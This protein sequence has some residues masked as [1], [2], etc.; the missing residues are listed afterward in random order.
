MLQGSSNKIESP[1]VWSWR[2]PLGVGVVGGVR[3]SPGAGVRVVE[4]DKEP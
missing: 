4:N 2:Q 3:K 1:G